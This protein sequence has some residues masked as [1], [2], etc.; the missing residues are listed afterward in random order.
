MIF[1]FSIANLPDK[2]GP[3]SL[4]LVLVFC[5]P[6]AFTGVFFRKHALCGYGFFCSDI[7]IEFCFTRSVFW[8]TSGILLLTVCKIIS[9]GQKIHLNIETLDCIPGESL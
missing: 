1:L 7:A 5:A 8:F 4:D 3:I 9:L 6:F 2:C